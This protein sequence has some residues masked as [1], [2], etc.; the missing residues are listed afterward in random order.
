MKL[1]KRRSDGE[2]DGGELKTLTKELQQVEEF[3]CTVKP[4]SA[5]D[6]DQVE[7]W[8]QGMDKR[9]HLLRTTWNLA[10]P[11]AKAKAKAKAPSAPSAPI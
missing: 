7:D 9:L 3:V 8:L 10:A 4:N 5:T 11:K 2:A 1:L 6:K